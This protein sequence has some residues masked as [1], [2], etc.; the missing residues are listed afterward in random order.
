MDTIR[1]TIDRILFYSEEG[2]YGVLVIEEETRSQSITV[3]GHFSTLQEGEVIACEGKW[4]QHPKHGRQFASTT[5]LVTA[6]RT[7]KG[8][9]K[10]LASDLVKGIGPKYAQQIVEV[11][12][13]ETLD[14][15]DHAPERLK[16]VKGIGPHRIAKILSSWQA[17]RSVREVMVFLQAHDVTPALA[18]K[19]YRAFG[20]AS[21]SK[22]KENP[23][24]LVHHCFG[25]GFKT[26]DH[27]AQR[28]GLEM[29]SPYR[30]QAGILHAMQE[31]AGQG[32]SCSTKENLIETATS[33]LEVESSLV[34]NELTPLVE[35]GEL[36][37]D[38]ISQSPFFWM[39]SIHEAECRIA[40]EMQRI[41]RGNC[42]IR[43]IRFMEA[44]DWLSSRF[45]LTFSE[46]Q[47]AAV[48]QSFSEKVQI[49][50]GGPGTGKSTITRGILSIS[51][52]LTK[53][54]TLAAPTGRA[55]KRMSEI[56]GYRSYT[57]H[58]LLEYDFKAQRFQRNR[59][60]PLSTDLLIVDEA[61]MIDVFLM[62]DLLEAIDHSTRLIL[63][64]DVD[65]LPSVGP[66]AV[67]KDLIESTTI[68]V[69]RLLTIFRQ[70]GGSKITFN[71]HRINAGEMPC[72]H[73]DPKSDFLFIKEEDP[74]QIVNN[75][76]S[77]V[78]QTL[79]EKYSFD[80]I[81]SIQVLAP[82]KRGKVGTEALNQ[83][84]QQILNPQS[85]SIQRMGERFQLADK[86]MQIKN[87]YDKKVFN[88]DIGRIIAIDSQSQ[89]V[90]VAFPH[91]TAIYPFSELDEIRLAY[92]VSIHKY[93]GSES[94][95]VI[96]PIHT[97]HFKLLARNLLYTGVTRGRKLV[98]L[99]GSP[100]AIAM[101]VQHN[102]KDQ[103]CTGL[104]HIIGS[105]PN[106]N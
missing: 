12:G 59:S 90:H 78:S 6:P 56:T 74:E 64:G 25:V 89:E 52:Q 70:R 17:Q 31:M 3:T 58:S 88:G 1:G 48:E 21:I 22:V 7:T 83:A 69:T 82:M 42:A 104:A 14:I 71:A 100:Q 39:A 81:D 57:I 91:T 36:I 15:I 93:Q 96:L 102:Q 43:G 68:P 19:I 20:D 94:P 37:E 65:Q 60:F 8:I 53:R 95:C 97:S 26:A 30:I 5:C 87:N 11:F 54:I 47:Q 67:L 106:E 23:Y 27:L 9:E 51:S 105:Y 13:E 92:A 73:P 85:T 41:T 28:L 50:T 79:P 46:E 29:T 76:L 34:V 55:A 4:V 77:L 10:Y 49:I 86:V 61:S 75:V 44:M 66:G 35:S 24:Y 99:V 62:A 32:H 33:L 84:L 80:P 72:V 38:H 101:A 103:R 40:R 63:I 45:S 18:Q 98:V 16:E 2:G